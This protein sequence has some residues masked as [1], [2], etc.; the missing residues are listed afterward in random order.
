[1]PL[2][3]R[4]PGIFILIVAGI[5]AV[6]VCAG[7]YAFA[8]VPDLYGFGPR[9]PAMGN[10]YTA[11]ADGFGAVYYN[12]A[13]LKGIETVD[14]GIGFLFSAFSFTPLDD[15][16]LGL[17][18]DNPGEVISGD[19]EF[20]VSDSF[21]LWGGF[22]LSI[23]KRMSAGFGLFL[24]SNRYLAVLKTRSQRE[25]HYF[26]YEDRPNRI[27]LLAAVSVELTPSLSVGVGANILFGP[28][29]R[30]Q[31]A[32]NPLEESHADLTLVFRP[33]A[34]PIVGIRFDPSP[35]LRLGLAYHEEL[36]HGDLDISMNGR[37]SL[38]FLTLPLVGHL[39]SMIF[40]APRQ[41]CASAAY[42]PTDGWTLAIEVGWKDWSCFRDASMG[43]DALVTGGSLGGL[44][45]PEVSLRF[46][47]VF[48][49][50][51]RD[52][53]VLRLGG[54]YR[55]GPFRPLQ[56]MGDLSLAFRCGYFFEPTPVPP[57]TGLTNFLDQDRHVITT[58][59]GLR[60]HDPFRIGREIRI[61]LFAQV[62]LLRSGNV[63]KSTDRFDLDGD[64]TKE[65]PVI[66]YPGYRV[67]G[68]ALVTA[69]TIGIEF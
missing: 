60:A 69:L 13:G 11:L 15:I 7:S 58:G 33:R 53:I 28:E 30:I 52:T 31:F 5:T 17:D 38:G 10:A 36:D 27:S 6:L 3:R 9:G 63:R 56:S 64:G 41:V 21:G 2:S 43:V 4:L 39:S 68:K 67:S 50:D 47:E 61:D 22:A 42:D 35:S 25:P 65:T 37:M 23:T 32:V 48:P 62:H 18:S 1:M 59:L 46:E 55:R 66:G 24:P 54:E 12:P 20:D 16:V 44:E 40:F 49:P 14:A 57:Q 45:L 51:F 29:G 26:R 19:I 34:A 8:N